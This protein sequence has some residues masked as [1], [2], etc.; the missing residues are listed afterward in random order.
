VKMKERDEAAGGHGETKRT[1]W[2]DPIPEGILNSKIP[3]SLNV[4]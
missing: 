3:T 4:Y 1:N 2:N